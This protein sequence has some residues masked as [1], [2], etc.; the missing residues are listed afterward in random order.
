MRQKNNQTYSR[1]GKMLEDDILLRSP[2]PNNWG[3][4]VLSP[5]VLV[6]G[7][8]RCDNGN[9]GPGVMTTNASDYKNETLITSVREINRFE[10]VADLSPHCFISFIQIKYVSA[11]VD[12]TIPLPWNQLPEHPSKYWM[13]NSLAEFLRLI[14]EW[15]QVSLEP[16]GSTDNPALVAKAFFENVEIPESV[17]AEISNLPDMYIARY[18]KGDPNARSLSTEY[19]QLSQ[20]TLEWFKQLTLDNPYKTLDERL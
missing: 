6:S 18:L 4:F 11:S 8:D 16:F 7:T 1:G 3:V 12:S 17:M 10:I 5:A 2:N 20:S 15:W 9:Y 19:P 13:G 14:W